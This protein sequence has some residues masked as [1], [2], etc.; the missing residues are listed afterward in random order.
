MMRFLVCLLMF[1]LMP[2]CMVGPHYKKPVVS[3]PQ[4]YVHALDKSE[5]ANLGTLWEIFQDQCLK[6]LIDQAIAD[7]LDLQIALERVEQFR[8]LY[9]I[10]QSRLFPEIDALAETARRRSGLTS[11]T[12]LFPQRAFNYFRFELATIWELDFWGRI[13]RARNARYAEYQAQIEDVRDV[14]LILLSNVAAAYIDIQSLEMII[15]LRRERVAID[16]ALLKLESGKFDAGLI[17]AF[18]V[19]Q[20]KAELEES[21]NLVLLLKTILIK[22]T[23]AL[24]LLVGQLPE[25]FQFPSKCASSKDILQSHREPAIGL[26][27]ELLRRRPDIRRAERLLAAANERVGEAIADYFP[28]FSLLGS[29]GR[30]APCL[31][32]LFTPGGLQWFIGSSMRWPLITFGRLRFS[33]DAAQSVERQA[34]LEYGQTVLKAFQDVE[35]ALISYS[36]DRERL[37]LL[38]RKVT[39]VTKEKDILKTRFD[40][41]LVDQQEYLIAE[42]NRLQVQEEQI[43]TLRELNLKVIRLYKALG[44]SWLEH[45]ENSGA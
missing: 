37:T 10:E 13:R 5:S 38:V 27:S 25:E 42:K 15:T 21:K 6:T 41:G 4:K 7:N 28:R 33:V 34:F 30:E 44:G 12:L 29:I 24:A 3:V 11:A 18:E 23:N 40:A 19:E 31:S 22:T 36:N 43:Q 32:N 35:D 20:I 9:F 14:Y 16:T 8:A 39:A 17:S 45:N 1:A 26:P 2:G